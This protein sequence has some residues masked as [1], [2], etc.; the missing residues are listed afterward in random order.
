M[1]ENGAAAMPLKLH[2]TRSDMRKTT[3]QYASSESDAE[4]D[5]VGNTIVDGQREASSER[6]RRR[7]ASWGKPGS[8]PVVTGNL[9][10]VKPNNLDF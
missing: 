8:F 2:D 7:M 5:N 3:V 4:T 10:E 9:E 6:R 1:Q